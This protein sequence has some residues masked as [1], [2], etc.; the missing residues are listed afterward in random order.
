MRAESVIMTRRGSQRA[1]HI[2]FTVFGFES[3]AAL[4]CKRATKSICACKPVCTHKRVL[5]IA[6]LPKPV[7]SS[8]RG[9][10]AALTGFLAGVECAQSD[11]TLPYHSTSHAE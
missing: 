9:R 8:H 6:V 7:S 4:I 11:I 5:L 1:C 10:I 3:L 2:F